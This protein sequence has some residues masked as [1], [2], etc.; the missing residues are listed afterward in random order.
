MAGRKRKPAK[1]RR[2]SGLIHREHYAFLEDLAACGG[3]SLSAALNLCICK[4]REDFERHEVAH[5]NCDHLNGYCRPHSCTMT[6]DL[7]DGCTSDPPDN[8][9][10]YGDEPPTR[11]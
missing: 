3:M 2:V 5:A 6:Y 11:H 8:P 10:L 4:A 7:V 9:L 1:S